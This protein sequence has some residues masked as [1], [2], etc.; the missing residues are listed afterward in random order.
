MPLRDEWPRITKTSP[1]TKFILN[2]LIRPPYREKSR[3]LEVFK[4]CVASVRSAKLKQ[5]FL[6]VTLLPPSQIF[7]L[8]V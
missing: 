5:I 8:R 6:A 4:T 2:V 1:G 3:N 7:T